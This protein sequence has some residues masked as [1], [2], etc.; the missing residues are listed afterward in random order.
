M[1]K[2]LLC[3]ALVLCVI[4][5]LLPISAFAAG[6]VA[7]GKYG[8]N[9]SWTL[10]SN[11]TLTVSGTGEMYEY[12]GVG[13]IPWYSCRDSI[14][15]VV[16]S[17]GITSIGSE[18]FYRCENL[19]SVT[20][21]NSV[22]TIGGMAFYGCSSLK[23]VT[24]PSSVTAIKNDAFQYCSSL[25]SVSIPDS[26]TDLG[27]W[28]FDHCSSLKSARLP[29]GIEVIRESLFS[30]CSSL[31][32]VAIPS[33]VKYIDFEA[34][35]KC[36]SL[37]SIT[38]HEGIETI[39]SY[40]FEYCSSLKSVNIPASVKR[41][42]IEAFSVNVCLSSIN[43]A[44]KNDRFCS[45]DG[46]LYNKDK[47]E[48]LQ[49]PC[50]K[51]DK[52]FSV[53]EGVKKIEGG[54]F[55]ACFNLTNI[56]LPESVAEIEDYAFSG[57]SSLNSINIPVAVTEIKE[58][59]FFLCSALEDIYYGGTERQWKAVTID[60]EDNECLFDARM[61]FVVNPFADVKDDAVYL[62]AVTW[63]S[64]NGIT[65]GYPDGSFRPNTLCT[66]AQVVTF[67]WRAAG[68]P[69]PTSAKNPFTDV[70]NEGSLMPYY[71]A[72]LWAVE[73]GI[74]SGYS[75]GSF[76]PNDTVTRA[77][78]VTFLWRY[79]RQPESTA[80]ITVFKDSANI[81]KP[82]QQAV[83][84]AVE[85]G[86]TTGYNDNTFRPNATCTRWQVVLFMYRDMK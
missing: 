56:T 34:F 58:G 33:S 41:I 76:R 60:D 74:T 68:S 62:K 75:D 39:G 64:E 73:K 13:A 69:E 52:T 11:G 80:S 26:V 19:T 18:A 45:V 81:S 2:R 53:P 72:I 6:T 79:E 42:G 71:K 70:K 25:E 20:I 55:S 12:S 78:F 36:E 35:Y 37:K 61:H 23:S 4:F 65:S 3:L 46:V 86:I 59:V 16:L 44:A 47:T 27:L 40:A 17:N 83:A 50:A 43:V 24:I 10:D 77:Q 31:E 85:K 21:P 84:W 8:S 22:K 29:N 9:L 51:T 54:A 82:Y 32:S 66:R 48:L 7:S 63:A 57:C 28:V 30:Y 49:Y 5:T 14:K 1:K 38:L 15:K 67:L